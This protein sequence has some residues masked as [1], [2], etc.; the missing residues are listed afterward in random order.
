MI[1]TSTYQLICAF[2]TELWE[3]FYFNN[4]MEYN[5]YTWNIHGMRGR[6]MGFLRISAFM[7]LYY[8]RRRKTRICTVYSCISTWKFTIIED[9]GDLICIKHNCSKTII[10]LNLKRSMLQFSGERGRGGSALPALMNNAGGLLKQY[11][12]TIF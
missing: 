1:Y 8:F 7:M 12:G 3:A 4:I 11:T 6:G 9:F 2:N 10:K 5:T